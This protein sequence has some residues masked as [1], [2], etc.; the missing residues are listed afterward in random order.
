MK[1][2]VLFPGNEMQKS[3]MV[4]FPA[5]CIFADFMVEKGLESCFV[6]GIYVIII[7]S[8]TTKIVQKEKKKS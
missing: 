7:A 3:Y 2:V 6:F 4:D 8:N 5:L 1:N